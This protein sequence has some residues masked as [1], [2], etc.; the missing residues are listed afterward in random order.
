MDPDANIA[1]QRDL[2]A[3]LHAS[4]GDTTARC[5]LAVHS[6]AL[7]DWLG[8]GGFHPAAADWRDVQAITDLLLSRLAPNK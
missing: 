3:R 8:R 6:Q 5:E 1:A 7:H 4:P 2:I